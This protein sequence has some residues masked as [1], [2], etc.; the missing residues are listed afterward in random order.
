MCGWT[1]KDVSDLVAARAGGGGVWEYSGELISTANGRVLARISDVEEVVIASPL[2]ALPKPS[3]AGPKNPAAL[4]R[5][6]P[7]ALPGS[8][9]RVSA[10][11]LT[12]AARI[13][14]RKTIFYTDPATGARLDVFRY[15]PT[16]PPRAVY[17]IVAPAAALDVALDAESRLVLTRAAR[18]LSAPPPTTPAAAA[19]AAA[20]AAAARVTVTAPPLRPMRDVLS[21]AWTYVG[22]NTAARADKS[23]KT[24]NRPGVIEEYS[25]AAG[26]AG[27]TGSWVRVGKCPSWYG[28]GQC[29]MS[30]RSVRVKGG[31]AG[32][33]IRLRRWLAAVNRSIP[34]TIEDA[35]KDAPGLTA[36]PPRRRKFLGLI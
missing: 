15:R 31:R 5:A 3:V 20:V 1:V 4:D 12:H 19:A 13:V 8:P 6:K 33:D 29:V 21:A 22:V 27:G 32:L 10:A 7:R 9:H 11:A 35:A 2:R 14:T 23:S 17:P 25:Y 16:A 28:G 36:S 24:P 30:L 18:P 26:R 34:L